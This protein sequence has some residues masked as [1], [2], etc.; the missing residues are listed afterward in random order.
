MQH[1]NGNW[2]W[3]AATEMPEFLLWRNPLVLAL[4]GA[5]P[6]G[7]APAAVAS[8]VRIVPYYLSIKSERMITGN[9]VE[10]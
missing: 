9:I 2:E 7:S 8:P 1:R 6:G 3:V 5:S 4:L 10:S